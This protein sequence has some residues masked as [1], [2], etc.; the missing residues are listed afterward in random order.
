MGSSRGTTSPPPAGSGPA[1]SGASMPR[2]L[3]GE[4]RERGTTGTLASGRTGSA[5]P[6]LV[7]RRCRTTTTLRAGDPCANPHAP[8]SQAPVT[9]G[10]AIWQGGGGGGSIAPVAPVPERAPHSPLTRIRADR[11]LLLGASRSPPAPAPGGPPPP[12]SPGARHPTCPAD[13]PATTP[14]PL[15]PAPSSHP[16]TS[17]HTPPTQGGVNPLCPMR[18]SSRLTAPCTHDIGTHER[19]RPRHAIGGRDPDRDPRDRHRP[20]ELPRAGIRPTDFSR[21]PE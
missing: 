11:R 21:R 12:R 19:R 8:C 2:A 9:G 17:L 3:L 18:A 6:P 14:P 10:R 20:D 7:R 15:R 4:P 13:A 16:A 5:A 1:S